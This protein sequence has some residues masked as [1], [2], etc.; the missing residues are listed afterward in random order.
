MTELATLAPD[1]SLRLPD[2]IARRFQPSDRFMVWLDG[3][4]LVLKRIIPSVTRLVEQAPNDEPMP[5]DEISAIVHEARQHR[6]A[7][8][9]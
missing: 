3:D 8:G 9:S 7:G 1:L 6:R 4:T 5:L 2:E